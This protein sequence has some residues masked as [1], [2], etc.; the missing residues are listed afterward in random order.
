MCTRMWMSKFSCCQVISRCQ[1]NQLGISWTPTSRQARLYRPHRSRISLLLSPLCRAFPASTLS[2]RSLTFSTSCP[3]TAI[4]ASMPSSTNLTSPKGLSASRLSRKSCTASLASASCAAAVLSSDSCALRA[5]SRALACLSAR[6]PDRR[7][8]W[9]GP[10]A[11]SGK[12][13]AKERRSASI[14]GSS[15]PAEKRRLPVL[16]RWRI[17]EPGPVLRRR[18]GE[19]RSWV[20]VFFLGVAAGTDNSE[21]AVEIR[22]VVA[23]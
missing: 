12:A 10:S 3:N 8:I 11:S 6:V 2:T 17:G 22:L 5:T 13:I 15:K 7:A 9:V 19:A 4:D 21:R 20:G 14:G 1:H 23:V 16:E 18:T